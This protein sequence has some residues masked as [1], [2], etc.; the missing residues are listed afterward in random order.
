[1]KASLEALDAFLGQHQWYIIDGISADPANH[2]QLTTVLQIMGL[3]GRIK[4][5]IPLLEARGLSSY[6]FLCYDWN[7]VIAAKEVDSALTRPMPSGFLSAIGHIQEG[8][9]S[10]TWCIR[11]DISRIH[12]EEIGGT[13]DVIR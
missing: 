6:V 10:G 1:V 7:Y 2:E 5:F 11:H 9:L 12:F 3:G 4:T 8:L 13:V